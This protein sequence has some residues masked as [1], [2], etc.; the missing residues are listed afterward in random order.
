M[1]ETVRVPSFPV[2]LLS[3]LKNKQTKILIYTSFNSHG[4]ICFCS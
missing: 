1:E 4:Q 2:L 3:Y